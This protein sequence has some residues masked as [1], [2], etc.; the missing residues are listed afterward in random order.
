MGVEMPFEVIVEDAPDAARDAA[1]GEPEISVGPFREARVES[2]VVRGAGG[3]QAR[4]KRFRIL[5]VGDRRVEVGAAAEPAPGRRQEAR[6]HMDRGHVRVRHV[7]DKADSGGKEAGILLGARNRFGEF[8]RE[9]AADGR[10]VDANLLEYLAR[11]LSAHAATA[12]FAAGV[13]AVPR[14]EGKTRLAPGFALDFLEGGTDPVAQRF[15]PIARGLL[16][17]VELEHSVSKRG[18]APR[19]ASLAAWRWGAA[20]RPFPRATS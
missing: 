8:W 19:R 1:V 9:R 15:E 5:V 10:D 16:L 18:A 4:M 13:G 20:R 3:A 12:R 11:H 14:R 6:V 2:R 17:V 7:R